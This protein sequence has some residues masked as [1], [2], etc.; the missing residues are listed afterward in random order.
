MLLMPLSLAY[1]MPPFEFLATRM[2]EM[3]HFL[4]DQVDASGRS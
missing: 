1:R 4:L 3:M 2:Q